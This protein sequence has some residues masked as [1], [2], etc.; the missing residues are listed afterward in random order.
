MNAKVVLA[1]CPEIAGQKQKAR[2]PASERAGEP[3]GVYGM[4]IEERDGDWVRTWAFKT[5]E[6]KAGREGFD[7]EKANGSLT[8]VDEY[9]GCPYCGTSSLF[10]CGSC[11]KISCYHGEKKM[12][13]PWCG[14]TVKEIKEVDAVE[15]KAG[16]M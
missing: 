11:G 7:A 12:V 6:K 8:P 5:D 14:K 13:C 2:A 10:Q 15:V 1:K 16:G 3:S 4:R 9:P